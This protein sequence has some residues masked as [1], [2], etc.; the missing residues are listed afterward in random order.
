IG[1]L[2]GSVDQ[3]NDQGD[4]GGGGYICSP[5]GELDKEDWD[6]YFKHKD[7]SGVLT[8]YG[9][10]IIDLSEEKG[11]DPVLFGAIALHETGYGTSRGVVDKKDR[12]STRLNSS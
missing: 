9:D 6:S 10:D 2:S 5:T 4:D 1:A 11:I 12:K 3:D 7:R 8:G